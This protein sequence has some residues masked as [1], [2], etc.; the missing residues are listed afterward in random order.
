MTDID[1]ATTRPAMRGIESAYAA[2]VVHP[3]VGKALGAF[4]PALDDV[5]VVN[6]VT[7]SAPMG[8]VTAAT[9]EATFFNPNPEFVRSVIPRVWD[10]AAPGDYLAAQAEA[11]APRLEE[12]VA[13]MPADERR[14]LADLSRRVTETAADD[15][16]GR[17][18]FA[19]LAALPWPEDDH[20]VIWHAAKLLR[21]HR[22]DGH[23]AALT[24]EGLGGV[25]ALIVHSAFDGIPPDLLRMS[26][27]WDEDSW[28][29]GIEGLR[30][31]GWLTDDDVPTLTAEGRER[32]QW[33]EDRTDELALRAYVPI[34]QEGVDRMRT[35]GVTLTRVLGDAGLTPAHYRLPP[36][37]D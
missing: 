37:T 29:A 21:E 16:E 34:G 1:P 12:G 32:R 28:A 30:W 4:D 13:A 31:R 10:L 36:P 6:L 11:F 8:A 2:G 22:G 9:V 19:A 17:T 25:E 24:V 5:A 20:L 23:V 33:I 26:R 18:L 7:R 15:T 35:L 14:E 27:R 3:H